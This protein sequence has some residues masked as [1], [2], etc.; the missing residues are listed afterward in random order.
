MRTLIRR[1]TPPLLH[2]LFKRVAYPDRL[3]HDRMLDR[4][5]TLHRTGGTTEF[6]GRTLHVPAMSGAQSVYPPYFRDEQMRFESDRP[7]PVI[8]DCG[9]HIGLSVLYWKHLYPGARI[10][11]IEADPTNVH[12]LRRNVGQLP[13]MTVIHAAVSDG[14]GPV[15][16]ATRGGVT[17]R[18]AD[19]CAGDDH[20]VAEVPTVSLRELLGTSRVDL[21][22]VDIEGSEVAVLSDAR[23]ELI[24]V[25]RIFV[26]YHSFAGQ[27]QELAALLLLLR[28]KGFRVYIST[29]E[30]SPQP[31]LN[32][33]TSDGM[34]M[35]LNIFAHRPR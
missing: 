4:L 22:K 6:L 30:I 19:L 5:T 17:G 12:A 25:E 35:R 14:P 1:I 34:D 24:N 32:H 18:M 11:A 21:L 27:S 15:K 23:E 3:T 7:D 16:F 33:R 9:S 10:T 13:D 26:E 2:D 20:V 28:G 29:E 8:I 31:F